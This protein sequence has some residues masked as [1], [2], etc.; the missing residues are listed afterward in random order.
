MNIFIVTKQPLLKCDESFMVTLIPNLFYR[1]LGYYMR[2]L[3]ISRYGVEG[4][5]TP[6]EIDRIEAEERA[7]R[8]PTRR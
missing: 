3:R 8:F 1:G 4:W 7:E 2:L 5:G 6:A